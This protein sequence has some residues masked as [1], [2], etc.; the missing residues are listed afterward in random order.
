MFQIIYFL[1]HDFFSIEN[2][3]SEFSVH[4]FR[5]MIFPMKFA[6]EYFSAFLHGSYALFLNLRKDFRMLLLILDN[7]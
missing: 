3:G 6:C 1:I 2:Y 5:S 4:K 7:I